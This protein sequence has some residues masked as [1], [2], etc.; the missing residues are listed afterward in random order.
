MPNRSL[1]SG[2]GHVQFFSHEYTPAVSA[3]TA[4]EVLLTSNVL[5]KNLYRNTDDERKV[6]EVHV[7]GVS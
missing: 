6:A 1:Q 4:A 5:N 2:I 3:G 7:I